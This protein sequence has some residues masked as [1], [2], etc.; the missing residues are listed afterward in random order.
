[1]KQVCRIHPDNYVVEIFLP[2]GVMNGFKP[3]QQPALAFNIHFRN[4]QHALD[5]FWSAPKD[6]LTQFRPNTWGP[7]YLEMPVVT[8]LRNAEAAKTPATQATASTN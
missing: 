1:V 4:F 6:I 2:A 5:Y 7:I 3:K 8:P